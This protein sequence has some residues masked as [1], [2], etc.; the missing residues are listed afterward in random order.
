MRGPY[1][2]RLELYKRMCAHNMDAKQL[3]GDL[4]EMITEYFRLFGDKSC[5]THDIALFLPTIS[6]QERQE[7]ASKLLLESGI[8]STT[9]PQNVCYPT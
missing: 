2:A 5:C 3:L 8:S 1:L 9:L 6:M 7:L 4:S